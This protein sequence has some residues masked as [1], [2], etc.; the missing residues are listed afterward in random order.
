[1]AGVELRLETAYWTFM[2]SHPNH[3]DLPEGALDDATE[4]LVWCHAGNEFD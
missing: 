1:M 3:R 2:Q 4:A